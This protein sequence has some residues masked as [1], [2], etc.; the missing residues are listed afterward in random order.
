MTGFEGTIRGRIGGRIGGIFVLL[1]GELL[2]TKVLARGLEV[3][4]EGGRGL[5]EL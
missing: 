4:V 2:G 5:A 1:G 3:D